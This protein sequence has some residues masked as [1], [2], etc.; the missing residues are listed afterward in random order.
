MVTYT[1]CLSLR[2]IAKKIVPIRGTMAKMQSKCIYSFA[3]I[4]FAGVFIIII[5]FFDESDW[6][7][8]EILNE[9]VDSEIHMY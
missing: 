3:H 7:S 6:A 2:N 8:T 9:V 1:S 5:I 4:D